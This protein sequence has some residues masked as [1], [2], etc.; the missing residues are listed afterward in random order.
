MCF[1]SR[2]TNTPATWGRSSALPVSFSTIEARV[3]IS[4]GDLIGRSAAFVFHT[5]STNF[6]W[7]FAIRVTIDWR[8]SPRSK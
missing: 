6:D 4:P 1:C 8:V 7:A 2:F 5:S 3:T